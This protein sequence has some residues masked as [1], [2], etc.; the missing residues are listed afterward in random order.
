MCEF[1]RIKQVV[2]IVQTHQLSDEALSVGIFKENIVR[3]GIGYVVISAK[4]LTRHILK[5]FLKVK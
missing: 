2:L 4:Q 1:L 5:H 3:G